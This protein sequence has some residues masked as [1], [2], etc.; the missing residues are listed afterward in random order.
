LSAAQRTVF[1][2]IFGMGSLIPEDFNEEHPLSWKQFLIAIRE[3]QA[4]D[5]T[6]VR[7]PA[8]VLTM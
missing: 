3:T 2:M 7:R 1:M 5:T 8:T 6:P 4:L